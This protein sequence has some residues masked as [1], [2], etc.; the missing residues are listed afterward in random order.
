MTKFKADL[1][2]SLVALIAS[3]E[4]TLIDESLFIM[5]LDDPL[6]V[7]R[8][9]PMED[10][11]KERRVRQKVSEGAVD[12]VV[13]NDLLGLTLRMSREAEEQR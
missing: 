7:P 13:D 11:D 4:P 2:I 9:R 1:I 6:R 5:L 8:K 12:V 3:P 10:D